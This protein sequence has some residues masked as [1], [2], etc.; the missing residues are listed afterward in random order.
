MK[1]AMILD[2]EPDIIN[3]ALKKKVWVNVMKE[4]LKAIERNKTWK[5]KV[6]SQNKKAISVR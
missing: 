1:S 6:L 3:E 4:E 5:L 2:F